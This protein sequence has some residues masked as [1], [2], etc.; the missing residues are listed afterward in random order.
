M[1]SEGDGLIDTAS[2]QIGLRLPPGRTPEE[3][4]AGVQALDPS[5][6]YDF[7]PGEPAVLAPKNTPLVASFLRSIRAEGGKP[8]FKVKTGTADM[9]VVGPVWGCP[10]VA[11][12]PGDSRLDHTPHEH[13]PLDLYL[14][15]IRVLTRVLEEL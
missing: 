4:Q 12:G 6:E 2:L 8:V 5:A 10:M 7:S 3:V 13:V 11:Y 9:N 14:A 1:W 15:A